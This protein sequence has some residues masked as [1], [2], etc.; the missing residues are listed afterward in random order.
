MQ[1]LKRHLDLIKI[2]QEI[3]RASK[4]IRYA[5]SSNLH[6]IHRDLQTINDIYNVTGEFTDEEIKAM[7]QLKRLEVCAYID[8]NI[9]KV[10]E[11]AS[12]DKLAE[13]NDDLETLVMKYI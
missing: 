12:T 7:N 13:F 5:D 1:N 10:V 11:S 4:I 2:D 9:A 8:I 6:D 3:V